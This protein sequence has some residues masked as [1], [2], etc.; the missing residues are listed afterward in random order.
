MWTRWTPQVRPSNH[1]AIG[2]PSRSKS[3]S[4]PTLSSISSMPQWWA[5]TFCFTLSASSYSSNSCV[6]NSGPAAECAK[7]AL[8]WWYSSPTAEATAD[9][10]AAPRNGPAV[11]AESP[12]CTGCTGVKSTAA[13]ASAYG[14]NVLVPERRPGLSLNSIV[15]P[16]GAATSRNPC[17]ASS[18]QSPKVA[19]L[20][21]DCSLGSIGTPSVTAPYAAANRRCQCSKGKLQRTAAWAILSSCDLGARI[22]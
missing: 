15:E 19:R 3:T 6:I 16:G 2:L 9:T 4:A 18:W 21:A 20:C 13:D 14:R 5:R 10:G 22:A 8:M 11:T 1:R 17:E 12:D 7:L